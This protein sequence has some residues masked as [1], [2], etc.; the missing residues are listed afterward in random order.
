MLLKLQITSMRRIQLCNKAFSCSN[1]WWM[2]LTFVSPN[3]IHGI[4]FRL[5]L[6]N[7][8]NNK[9]AF[10]LEKLKCSS[11][12]NIESTIS[13]QV[14]GNKQTI[15]NVK[16]LGKMN[17]YPGP[18]FSLVLSVSLNVS[19]FTLLAECRFP[20]LSSFILFSIFICSTSV[21]SLYFLLFRAL[22][23]SSILSFFYNSVSLHFLFHVC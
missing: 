15:W 10:I 6:T 3:K 12:K 4:H 18:V 23:L 16:L 17:R 8:S 22:S 11:C 13:S 7:I 19:L 14:V 5:W 21:F 1:S 20:T 2:N 9:T